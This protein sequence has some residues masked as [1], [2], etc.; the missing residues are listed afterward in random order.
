MGP[1]G[2]ATETMRIENTT[3]S[4][5]EVAV[6][7]AG[8]PTRFWNDLRLAVWPVGTAAPSPLPPLLWWT[9]QW[10]QLG[11]LEPG[12]AVTY[13]VQLYLP[14]SAGNEDQQQTAVF[15]LVWHAQG[16]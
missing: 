1:G 4:A 13:E 12:R 11:T 3:S 8:T 16:T 7:I 9:G 6:R 5:F 14:T 10:N 2:Q 15:D